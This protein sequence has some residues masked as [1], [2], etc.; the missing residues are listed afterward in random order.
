MINNVVLVSGV[1]HGDSVIHIHV[2][3]L[4]Q[5]LVSR[6]GIKNIIIEQIRKQDAENKCLPTCRS[7]YCPR[8]FGHLRK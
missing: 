4:F 1:Q 7:Q 2:S 8:I 6:E 5:I 3:V